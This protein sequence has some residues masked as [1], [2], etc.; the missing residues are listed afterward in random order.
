M[1]APGSPPPGGTEPAPGT[2]SAPGPGARRLF[3][4][5]RT[6]LGWLLAPLTWVL[7]ALVRGYQKFISPGLPPSCRFAPSCSQYT[8]EAL[9][10][11]GALRG[12][13]LGA[14]RLVRCHPWHPGGYDPVP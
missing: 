8:L 6:P 2:S 11:H 13:W 14:R 5:P 4:V 9:Q 3:P 12:G 10:R 1:P 7:I